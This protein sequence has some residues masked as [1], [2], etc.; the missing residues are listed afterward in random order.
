MQKEES[1]TWS[2][3]NLKLSSQKIKKEKWNTA[4]ELVWHMERNN[5]CWWKVQKEKGKG[6]KEYLNNMSENFPKLGREID[7]YIHE[8][9]RTLNG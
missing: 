7:I 3:R 1:A 5:N 2:M 8:S 9:Q 4:Y 6:Q